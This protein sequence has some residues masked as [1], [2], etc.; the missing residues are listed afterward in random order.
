MNINQKCLSHVLQL[1]I[2]YSDDGKCIE[3]IVESVDNKY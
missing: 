2:N 1:V 3:A